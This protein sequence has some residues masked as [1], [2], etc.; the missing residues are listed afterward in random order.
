MED[1][2]AQLASAIAI[3]LPVGFKTWVH[4]NREIDR[5]S[6]KVSAFLHGSGIHSVAEGPMSGIKL[7]KG[8]H[9][10]HAHLRGTYE[11]DVLRAVNTLV[12]PGMVCYDLGASIGYLSLLMARTA[13][14][15][16]AFEPAPHA[17][18]ELRKHVATNGFTNVTVVES[19]VT[20]QVREVVF[21]VTDV[22]YGSAISAAEDS[23]WKTI[24][25]MTTTL[26]LFGETHP[27]PDFIKIDVEGEE[28][29]VLEGARCLLERSHPVICCEIHSLEQAHHVQRILGDFGYRITELDISK[30]FSA[31]GKDIV[32]GEFQVVCLP[33]NWKT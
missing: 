4:N 14:Q 18:A 28:G 23:R 17:A 21:A 25:L 12:K 31:I 11:I 27:A 29:R 2:L 1:M 3:S 8:E 22:A 33:P 13:K 10:S 15:V 20:D 19:P 6:R 32:A 5:V 16:F 30:P 26:D 7:V 9:V 24:Q